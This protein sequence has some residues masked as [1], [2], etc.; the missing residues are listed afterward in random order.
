MA[1][2]IVNEEGREIGLL[3]MENWISH[4][5]SAEIGNQS[6]NNQAQSFSVGLKYDF[7]N[8][9]AMQQAVKWAA[10]QLEYYKACTVT[11]TEKKDPHFKLCSSSGKKPRKA[12][13]A[14]LLESYYQRPEEFILTQD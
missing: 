4:Q 7:D 1:A 8:E 6:S 10:F 12:L 3:E 2:N 5:A 9:K 13:L 11:I 14:G